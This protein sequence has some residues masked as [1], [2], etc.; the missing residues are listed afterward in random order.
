MPVDISKCNGLSYAVDEVIT[1]P[2]SNNEK[3]PPNTAK[4]S[5]FKTKEDGTVEWVAANP[6]SFPIKLILNLAMQGKPNYMQS[7]DN[8]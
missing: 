5:A 1:K 7:V 6:S 8:F 3:I 2:E 4:D